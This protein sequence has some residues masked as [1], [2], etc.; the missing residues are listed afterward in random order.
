MSTRMNA[1]EDKIAAK[2][3]DGKELTRKS[4]GIELSLVFVLQL[5]FILGLVHF[6][7]MFSLGGHLHGLVG[8]VFILLPTIAMDRRDRPYVRYGIAA[9]APLRDL[10]WTLLTMALVFP[11]VVLGTLLAFKVIG[12]EIWGL[13]TTH[14]RFAWPDGYPGVAISHFVVVALPEEYF[15]RGYVMGRLDDIFDSRRRILGADVGWSLILSSILFALGHY[16]IDFNPSRLMV[17]FS[18]LAFGWLRARLGTIGGPIVLHAAS[19][20][21]MEIFRAGYGLR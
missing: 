21:F 14:W 3:L 7:R 12:P 16:L 15:Y 13:K 17:F 20:I 1:P 18:A 6:D 8:L 9:G 2:S 4:M 5:L 19:N 11:L 10:L